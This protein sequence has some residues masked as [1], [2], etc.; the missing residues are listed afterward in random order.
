MGPLERPLAVGRQENPQ[1]T[2]EKSMTPVIPMY[3]TPPSELP[4]QALDLY[5]QEA[6]HYC[7]LIH[8]KV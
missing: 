8:T 5:Q 7:L 3:T 6:Q 1:T 4:T 2:K